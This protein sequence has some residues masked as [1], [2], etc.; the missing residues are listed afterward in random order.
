MP[1]LQQEYD[2]YEYARRRQG[3]V[4]N[5]V[6]TSAVRKNTSNKVS[7]TKVNPRTLKTTTTREVTRNSTRIATRDNDFI[8]TKRKVATKKVATKAKTTSKKASIDPVVFNSKKE[9]K[10]PQEMKLTKPKASLNAKAI[11]KQKAKVKEMAKKLFVSTLVFGM[12]FLICYRYS[13]I[14][15][16]FNELNN[17][18]QD[19]RNKQTINAQLEKNIKENTNLEEIEIYAKYQLGMQKPKESQIQK[20]SIGKQDKI[21]TPVVVEEEQEDGIIAKIAKDIRKILD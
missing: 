7:S 5:T 12:F 17:L 4:K 14:N 1:A 20:I 11:Q 15:E 19:V 9:I 8:G 6:P 21:I 3:T 13:S 10:K 16:S 2:Y 18:K